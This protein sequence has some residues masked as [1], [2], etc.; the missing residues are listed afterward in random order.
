MP[1]PL[2]DLAAARGVAFPVTREG[3][4]FA[5]FTADDAPAVWAFA[6][7]EEVWTWTGSI[8]ADEADLCRAYLAAG[9]RLVVRD[10]GVLVGLAKLAV[11]DG[12]SHPG[13]E[14]EARDTQAEIGWTVDPAHAG[15]GHAT[16]IAR[17]LLRLGFED[18]GLRRVEAEAFADN[19]ASRR[20]MEKAGL[21]HEGTF[22]AE[23][24]HRTR[25]WIDGCSYALLAHEW[26][27][28]QAGA[29]HA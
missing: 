27:A 3:L 19:G 25:G 5:P 12:W 1:T 22:V 17:A 10:R 4:D 16:R 7:L 8:P 21:R 13:R 6:G 15:R 26:R 28:A 18:L 14:A 9:D 23:S 11:Q 20:V 29:P 2:L 24:L